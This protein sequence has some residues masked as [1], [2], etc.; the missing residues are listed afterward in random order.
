MTWTDVF[1]F[2]SIFLIFGSSFISFY[3][4]VYIFVQLRKNF[5]GKDICKKD[6]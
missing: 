1:I 4:L 6:D 2:T 3:L 5:R